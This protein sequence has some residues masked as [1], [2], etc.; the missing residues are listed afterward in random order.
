MLILQGKST[1]HRIVVQDYS[2]NLTDFAV[3]IYQL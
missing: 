1:H 3:D 2:Q